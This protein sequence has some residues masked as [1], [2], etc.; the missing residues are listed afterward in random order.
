VLAAQPMID[1]QGLDLEVGEDPV[2]PGQDDVGGYLTDDMGILA[3]A[4]SAGI[5]GPT[6]GLCGGTGGE[7][8]GDKATQAGGRIIGDLAEADAAR[9]A[10]AILDL[11]APTTS[12]LP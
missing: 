8:D 2:D 3:D 6:V 11:T 1:A 5:P 4:S 9:S 10:T 7:V 12:I